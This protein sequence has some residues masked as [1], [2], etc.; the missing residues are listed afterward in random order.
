MF[1]RSSE[2]CQWQCCETHKNPEFHRRTKHIEVK[3]NFVKEKFLEGLVDVEHVSTTDQLADILTKP[4]N[5]V[6]FTQL[7]VNIGLCDI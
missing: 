6:R 4:L 2:N 7:K 1:P 3:Y 5:R